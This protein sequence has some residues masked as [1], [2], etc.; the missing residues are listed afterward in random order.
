[1]G[2]IEHRMAHHDHQLLVL[3]H[4]LS[5]QWVILSLN[6]SPFSDP[7]PELLLRGPVRLTVTAYDE[8]CLLLFTFFRH[9]LLAAPPRPVHTHTTALAC[10]FSR[11]QAT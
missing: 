3:A 11:D 6:D 5:A 1:M 2:Q 4:K 7:L 10:A 8:G 9:L